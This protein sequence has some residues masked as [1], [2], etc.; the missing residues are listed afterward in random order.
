MR[1]QRCT[2]LAQQFLS[3]LSVALQLPPTLLL[4]NYHAQ[5]CFTMDLIRYPSISAQV[6]QSETQ[7]RMS[8][9]ADFDTVTLLFQENGPHVPALGGLEAAL[10]GSSKAD[11]SASYDATGIWFDVPPRQ[12]TVLVNVGHMLKRWTNGRWDSLIHRVGVPP[13]F[14]WALEKRESEEDVMIPER[15]SIPFFVTPDRGTTVEAL[16]GTWDVDT[17]RKWGP[18]DV[19][20]F[21]RRKRKVNLT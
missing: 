6:L 13:K 17:P 20:D 2:T 11:T 9:H 8:A 3:C 19:K 18:L 15:F 4:E 7:R 5:A 16:P 14:K 21:L 1:A 12:G 10:V